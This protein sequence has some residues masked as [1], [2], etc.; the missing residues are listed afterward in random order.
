[1]AKCINRIGQKFGKL[2]IIGYEPKLSSLEKKRAICVCDCGGNKTVD[3]CSLVGG[4]TRSCGCLHRDANIRKGDGHSKEPLYKVYHSMKQRCQNPNSCGF[5][6]YGGR[7]I[8]VSVEWSD[9]YYAF[10][11]WAK[12]NGYAEG[13]QI[14]RIDVNGNYEPANCRWVSAKVN[15]NNQR[16][17]IIITHEGVTRP[18]TEW[19]A[20]LGIREGTLRSRI[21]EL[22]MTVEEA[23][24]NKKLYK[25]FRRRE[26][27]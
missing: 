24:Q 12:S 14:D 5:Q 19:A 21:Q 1:M 2:T 27:V 20:V 17:T 10:R 3:E 6:N 18:I 16:K 11:S 4:N 26:P 23:L 7:G 9:S 13:L 8:S 15:G 22:G 25:G